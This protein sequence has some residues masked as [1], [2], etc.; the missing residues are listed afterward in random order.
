MLCSLWTDA[1]VVKVECG[2][3]LCETKKNE[4][5]DEK[6]RMLHCFVVEQWRDVVLLVDRSHC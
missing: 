4:R 3:C 6:V 1:I 5:F 2:E